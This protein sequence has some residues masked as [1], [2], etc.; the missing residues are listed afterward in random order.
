MVNTYF[1]MVGEQVLIP[2]ESSRH[3]LIPMNKLK[4]GKKVEMIDAFGKKG[5]SLRKKG[6]IMPLVGLRTTIRISMIF[7]A[8]SGDSSITLFV[9][10]SQLQQA[11]CPIYQ[12]YD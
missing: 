10:G 3:W 4:K 9:V 11:F 2:P 7:S 12:Q 5:V 6:V 1:L 8:P